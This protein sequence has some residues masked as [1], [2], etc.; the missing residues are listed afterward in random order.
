MTHMIQ[1]KKKITAHS[2]C[3]THKRSLSV[4]WL[5]NIK[6]FIVP[7]RSQPKALHLA[8]TK[9]CLCVTVIQLLLKFWRSF[10]KLYN[11]YVNA[12]KTH[13]KG[14]EAVFNHRHLHCMNSPGCHWLL[15]AGLFVQEKKE[16][17]CNSVGAR[18]EPSMPNHF[19]K[20]LFF[21][22]HKVTHYWKHTSQLARPHSHS[23]TLLG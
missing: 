21:I 6:T 17:R 4:N 13:M 19:S 10:H 16:L 1:P 14:S 7:V 12:N 9:Y 22:K 18:A 20:D 8:N 23:L 3:S 15:Q 11:L 2:R 5:N